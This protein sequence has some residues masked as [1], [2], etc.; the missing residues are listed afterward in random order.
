MEILNLVGFTQ[1]LRFENEQS[2]SIPKK[3]SVKFQPGRFFVYPGTKV[4]ALLV[5]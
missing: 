4:M 2:F 5:F 3:Y 1:S